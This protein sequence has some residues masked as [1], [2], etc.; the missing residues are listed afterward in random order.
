MADF[1]DRLSTCYRTHASG[2]KRG[3]EELPT[4]KYCHLSLL[5]EGGLRVEIN[6]SV[7]PPRWWNGTRCAR[8]VLGAQ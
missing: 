6:A 7:K 4:G 2:K 5:F 8:G 1:L 3:H